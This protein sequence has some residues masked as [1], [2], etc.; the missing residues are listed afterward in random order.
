MWKML[1]PFDILSVLV[2][3]QASTD[4]SPVFTTVVTWTVLP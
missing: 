3:P 2:D 1:S 4:N